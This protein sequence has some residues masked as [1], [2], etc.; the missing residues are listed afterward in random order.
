MGD[1]RA[2]LAGGCFH[3]SS[4]LGFRLSMRVSCPRGF[5]LGLL[6][7]GLV[8]A[9]QASADPCAPFIEEHPGWTSASFRPHVSALE[10]CGVDEA[11]YRRV[12]ADWLQQRPATRPDVTSLSLGRAVDFPWI[13]RFLADAALRSPD[14]ALRVARA[15]SGERDRLA[16]PILRDAALL[17]RLAAPYAGSRYVVI[18]LSYEKVLFGRADIHASPPA[19]PRVEQAAATWDAAA[20]MVPYDA[21]IWLRLAPRYSLA[22]TAE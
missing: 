2:G 19:P 12:I 10:S 22:P 17:Q 15:R 4:N 21:Q 20:V 9:N 14:W 13:S 11:R 6:W 3:L 16:R 7:A 18:G 5:R 8:W 1:G